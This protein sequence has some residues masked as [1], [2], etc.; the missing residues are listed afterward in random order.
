MYVNFSIQVG[1]YV[2]EWC[3][4]QSCFSC[5]KMESE[6]K[7][8]KFKEQEVQLLMTLVNKYK[9]IIENKKTDA[10]TWKQKQTTWEEITNEFNANNDVY[11]SCKNIKGKYENL[12]KNAKKKFATEKRNVYK[13]GGGVDKPVLITETDQKIKE[14]I[15]ISLEG[16]INQFDSDVIEVVNDGADETVES[17]KWSG[18]TPD[19]LKTIKTPVLTV[20]Q[21]KTVHCTVVSS[22]ELNEI[23]SIADDNNMNDTELSDVVPMASNDQSDTGKPSVPV[24]T[25]TP[26]AVKRKR[27]TN[28]RTAKKGKNDLTNDCRE[29]ICSFTCSIRIN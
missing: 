24:T 16:L 2:Y 21:D 29:K 9:V 13:T 28:V 22:D 25:T 14:I 15:G 8:G 19:K 1:G 5:L 17:M 4:K 18:W 3:M 6:Y 27:I 23:E 12:K 20:A 7:Y 11:R 10:I 26:I